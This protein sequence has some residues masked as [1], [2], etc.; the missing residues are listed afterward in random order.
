MT[1]P[2]TPKL[3]SVPKRLPYAQAREHVLTGD[4]IALRSTRGLM[5][6]LIKLIT[7]SPYTHT[8]VA[9]WVGHRLLVAETRGGPA[10]LVPLS[11]YKPHDFDVFRAPVDPKALIFG[12][13]VILTLLGTEIDYAYADLARVALHELLGVP[14]PKV[15]SK[16]SLIC[17][18]LSEL[19]YRRLGWPAEHLPSIPTPRDL[20]NAIGGAPRL[21]V[22]RG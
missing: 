18:A 1:A 16:R 7:R 9:I 15:G 5:A 21:E 14:L 19:I 4:L 11:Q 8:G 17:S 3:Q 20:V 12:R 10:S 6:W 22:R 2:A 13:D